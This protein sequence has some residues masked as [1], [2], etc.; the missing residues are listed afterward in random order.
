[1]SEASGAS[2]TSSSQNQSNTAIGIVIP[3]Q[4]IQHA[5]PESYSSAFSMPG[6][7]LPRNLSSSS[8]LSHHNQ[9]SSSRSHQQSLNLPPRSSVEDK[10]SQIQ[11]YIKITSSLL[12]S[13]QVDDVSHI[14]FWKPY[15]TI[16]ILF[17]Y[18]F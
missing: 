2:I 6:R 10:L 9:Q 14:F 18:L 12:N 13:M 5:D 1:M 4:P 3:T 11:E 16:N 17:I 7:V 15:F 8:S